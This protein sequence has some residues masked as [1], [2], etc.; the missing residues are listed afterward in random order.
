MKKKC[1]RCSVEK[2]L[3]FEKT[4]TYKIRNGKIRSYKI[5][6]PIN[7][8]RKWKD[9]ICGD[10]ILET[11]R[12]SGGFDSRWKSKN[13]EIMA[14]VESEKKAGEFF[15]S[16]GFEVEHTESYGPD[17]RCKIGDI[18]WTIEVKRC[19]K[20]SGSWRTGKVR[21]ARKKDDLVAIVLPNGRIYVDSMTNHLKQSDVSDRRI[22]TR[23]V[24]EFG[25]G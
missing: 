7:G 10:C 17:L 21:V 4:N 13:R 24:K 2:E 1:S 5:F 12:K 16:L 23:I 8:G 9:S 22:V 14:F 6:I 15:R 3:I 18:E 19:S 25:L 20:S 11:K